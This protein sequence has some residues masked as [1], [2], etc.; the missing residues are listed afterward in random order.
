MR[1]ECVVFCKIAVMR[2]KARDSEVVERSCGP[3]G[4]LSGSGLVFEFRIVARGV[5]GM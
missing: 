1:S 2:Q 3:G 5:G 4:L